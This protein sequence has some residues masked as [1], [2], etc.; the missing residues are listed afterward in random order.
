MDIISG[1]IRHLMLK[2]GECVR[3]FTVKT[4]RW[5]L[6]YGLDITEQ[7]LDDLSRLTPEQ[8]ALCTCDK[9]ERNG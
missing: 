2:N 3:C 6:L 8:L 5:K 1:A 4:L 9:K 7:C